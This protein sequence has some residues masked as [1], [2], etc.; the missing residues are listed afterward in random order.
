M[1]PT[2]HETVPQQHRRL[3]VVLVLLLGAWLLMSMR[4]SYWHIFCPKRVAA[5]EDFRVRPVEWPARRGT[6]MD[7]TGHI[8]A[9]DVPRYFA[10]CDPSLVTK[11]EDRLR[12]ANEIAAV[13]TAN[14]LDV[15]KA[16]AEP[17]SPRYVRLARDLSGPVARKLDEVDGIYTEA[18]HTRAYPEGTLAAHLLGF[19]NKAETE[20]DRAGYGLEWFY[21]DELGG[22]PGLEE[23]Y[24]GRWGTSTH[25]FRPPV[26]GIDIMLTINRV[27]QYEAE[28]ALRGAVQQHRATGGSIIVMDPKTGAIIAMA[29]EPTYDPNRYADFAENPRVFANASI[30]ENYEPGSVF[31]VIT[32]AAALDSGLVRPE[33]TYTDYGQILVGG[34]LFKNALDKSYGLVDMAEILVYSLNVGAA[35]LSTGMRGEA[36][37]DYVH[38]FGFG[39]PTGVDLAGEASGAVQLPG[40]PTWAE[41]DLAANAFG[42]AI[43]VTPLQ[44][45]NAIAAVANGGKLM[46]PY[47]VQSKYQNGAWIDTQPEVVRQVISPKA[48]QQVTA[49][50]EETVERSYDVAAIPGYRIA[51]KTGSAEIA[52]SGGYIADESAVITSFVGFLPVEDPRFVI[53]VKVDRPQSGFWG[54]AVALPVFQQLASRL[55]S[56]YDVAPSQQ[57]ANQG[58][59]Q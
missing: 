18:F 26:D 10:C 59:G 38:R 16:I 51:G 39:S 43:S 24:D 3:A 8:L 52:G 25:T 58:Y 17:P 30:S 35:R 40:S 44:M 23:I 11:D 48:A 32:M 4:F 15:Y 12:I 13:S 28:K 9:I 50:M 54:S 41:S 29:N 34:R 27:A 36:F 7:S 56:L 55:L 14:P 1:M 19:V 5:A 45:V 33:D 22:Q 57:L 21:Y 47:V 31:K 6:I 42:Q 49:M 20:E 2:P 37:Y 46:R 53:L